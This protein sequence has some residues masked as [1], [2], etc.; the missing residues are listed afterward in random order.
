MLKVVPKT[1]AWK[2]SLSEIFTSLHASSPG[3]DRLTEMA[4]GFWEPTMYVAK[5]WVVRQKVPC[6][7]GIGRFP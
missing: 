6:L 1:A 7:G 2:N 4:L 5:M 3:W